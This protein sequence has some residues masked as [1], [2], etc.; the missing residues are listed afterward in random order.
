MEWFIVY[1]SSIVK[2]INGYFYGHRI[3]IKWWLIV[4]KAVLSSQAHH[5]CFRNIINSLLPPQA[6][7]I[8]T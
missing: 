6:S 7:F 8:F 5:A 3:L 2:L 4:T 1:I